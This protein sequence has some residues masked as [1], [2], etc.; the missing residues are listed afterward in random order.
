MEAVPTGVPDVGKFVEENQAKLEQLKRER[1]KLL[2]TCATVGGISALGLTLSFFS[3]VVALPPLF[4][5][6]GRLQTISQR[7]L[8]MSELLE[9]F[10]DEDIRI[11][12]ALDTDEEVRPIDFFLRFPDRE[13]ILIQ[14]RSMGGSKVTYNEEKEALR[15]RKKG[16][17]VKSWQ[18][19]PLIELVEQERWVRRQ[20][21][22][23]LGKTARE[24]R[25]PMAKV[26]VLWTDT[27]I[28]D[29]PEHLYATIND[30]KYLT[31]RKAGTM[32]V[33]LREQVISFVRDYLASRRSPKTPENN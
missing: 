2:L 31:I 19:D 24:R 17:G 15:F 3:A 5:L 11:E 1:E 18:P 33:L 13:Y 4:Q 28:G 23:L 10:E 20:R 6:A 27:F 22:D 8:L 26:L 16:R 12:V 9:N 32:S 25:R 30:Q 14:I 29:H 21:S 7:Y